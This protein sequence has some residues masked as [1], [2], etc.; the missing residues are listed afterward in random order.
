MESPRPAAPL[1]VAP[2]RGARD[3]WLLGCVVLGL[4]LRLPLLPM[5]GYAPDV[6]YWKS[7]LTY[8][9]SFGIQNIY[10]LET[11]L[12]P[13]PP[14]LLILLWML[15]MVYVTLWPA[16]RD[17][18]GLTALVKLPAAAADLV[19]AAL[20]A[21]Y[22]LRR[23]GQARTGALLLAVNPALIW[24]SS[25]WGQVDILHAG[26]AAAAWAAI[27]A[28]RPGLAG[29]L[30][31]LGA[32]TKP[33]GLLAVPAGAALVAASSGG[34]GIA[35]AMATGAAT[36]AI[37]T[38]PF[39]LSGASGAL[40][41]IYTGAP[42]LYPYLSLNAFNPWWIAA[43]TR[44]GDPSFPL[45]PDDARWLGLVTP[46]TLGQILLLLATAAITAACARLR[47]G[48]AERDP[49]A[50]RLLTLQWLAFFLLPTQVH[51]RYLLPAMVSMAPVA[52][53]DRRWRWIYAAMTAAVWAN[54]AY[55]LPGSGPVRILARMLSGE[56]VLA[57]LVLLGCAIAIAR[58]EMRAGRRA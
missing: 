53:L 49:R 20:L 14:V 25:Y 13:Y 3:P 36:V 12:Q 27:L 26:M 4:L 57:A 8:A 45:V 54:V 29:S 41:R 34:R 56:G 50:W 5:A 24:V 46:R 35:R 51:E 22:V 2:R 6:A 48:S 19:A 58:A 21:A 43:L 18:P 7:H 9:T 39:L 47:P 30:L 10:G 38:S 15:G 55:V 17:T 31:A 11:P 32:L 1:Q 23:A 44:A 33:Q 37:V 42:N 40:L 28:G 52:A 16:A